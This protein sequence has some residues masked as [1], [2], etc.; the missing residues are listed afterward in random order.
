[1]PEDKKLKIPEEVI[2][3]YK[4]SQ[5]TTSQERQEAAIAVQQMRGDAS[6]VDRVTG[7]PRKNAK[8]W[9][10]ESDDAGTYLYVSPD[11]KSFDKVE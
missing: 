10:L 11:R 1:M 8:G 3:Y 5:P 2:K 4:G 6:G 7:L 9:T